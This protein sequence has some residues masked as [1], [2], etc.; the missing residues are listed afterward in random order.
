MNPPPPKLTNKIP[1]ILAKHSVSNKRRGEMNYLNLFANTTGEMEF[2]HYQ[3]LLTNGIK[4][5]TLFKGASLV[6]LANIV[7]QKN[8]R[9][10]LSENGEPFFIT[11]VGTRGSRGISWTEIHDLVAWKPEEDNFYTLSG[12]GKILN[13]EATHY[14][15]AREEPL[16][17]HDTVLSWFQGG[18]NGLVVLDWSN[19]QPWEV[20][21]ANRRVVA[22]TDKSKKK[23]RKALTPKYPEIRIRSF[24][25]G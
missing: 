15:D 6:G 14:A 11:P 16:F 24:S 19:I 7:P 12:D 8:K 25:N 23:L 5:K 17:I 18:C 20:V 10:I 3:T 4:R 2:H 9:F 13:E 1:Y 21:G 22:D